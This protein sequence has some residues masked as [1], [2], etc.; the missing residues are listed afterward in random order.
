[1]CEQPNVKPGDWITINKDTDY[2]YNAVVCSFDSIHEGWVEIVYLENQPFSR[3]K[4]PRKPLVLS[5]PML[6]G[7]RINGNELMITQMK[8][9]QINILD[10]LSL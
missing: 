1:M 5:L 4:K 9:M 6:Y 3:R 2:S 7:K 8:A 10:L